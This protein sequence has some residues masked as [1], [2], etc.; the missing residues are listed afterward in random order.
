MN[1]VTDVSFVNSHAESD[2][3]A[4]DHVLRSHELVLAG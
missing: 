3:G 2:R 1:D 4:D